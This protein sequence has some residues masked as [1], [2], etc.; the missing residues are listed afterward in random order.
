MSEDGEREAS[1]AANSA[2]NQAIGRAL[3]SARG[4]LAPARGPWKGGLREHSQERFAEM[5]SHL[6]DLSVPARTLGAYEKAE[7]TIPAWYLVAAAMARKCSVEDLLREAGDPLIDAWLAGL[8]ATDGTAET[9]EAAWRERMEE[10]VALLREDVS[11]IQSQVG[12]PN[13][14]DQRRQRRTA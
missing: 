10:E 12:I 13:Q 4:S 3:P 2:L 9:E 1:A 6:A 8:A 5:I 7:R 14:G 11:D